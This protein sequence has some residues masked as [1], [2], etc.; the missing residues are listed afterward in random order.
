[1]RVLL[2]QEREERIKASDAIAEHGDKLDGIVTSY[3]QAEDAV[4]TLNSSYDDLLKNAMSLTSADQDYAKSQQDIKDQQAELMTEKAGLYS[5]EIEKINDVQGKID[6]L[7]LK[8]DE[9][10]IEHEKRTQRVLLD[11]SLEKIAMSDGEAG[12]S[13]AEYN[14]ALALAE[15]AG[16][17]EASA[18][19]QTAA[20]DAIS[21]AMADPSQK[22]FDMKLA[23]EEM[24]AH[25]WTV[26][27]AIQM[28]NLD[29]LR[30]ALTTQSANV[31]NDYGTGRHENAKGGDF[32][33]PMS[34]GNEGF[35]MGNGDTA[36]GGE[37]VSITPKGGAGQPS[38]PQ[39][40]ERGIAKAIVGE[41]LKHGMGSTSR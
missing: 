35:K 3:K 28:Q 16:A 9:N 32:L 33:I 13:E 11:M 23:L 15:T 4:T 34:Y 31:F 30:E 37:R 10:A 41:M 36:S 14:K 27:V 26:D 29:Q 39:L 19:R 25:G 40:T 8:Y 12:F 20:M 24:T 1:M 7:S 17:A 22:I 21:T 2:M 6:D 18:I 5:W 38:A